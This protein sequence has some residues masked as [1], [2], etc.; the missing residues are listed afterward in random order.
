MRRRVFGDGSTAEVR[1]RRSNVEK[2]LF[3]ETFKP[4]C[5]PVAK[6]F[7]PLVPVAGHMQPFGFTPR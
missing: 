3:A 4:A 5:E 2:G 7:H 1:R 6:T